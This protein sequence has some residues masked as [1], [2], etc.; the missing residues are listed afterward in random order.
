MSIAILALLIENV[1][2]FDRAIEC[3]NGQLTIAQEMGDKVTEASA[4]SNL[5]IVY[6]SLGKLKEAIEKYNKQMSTAKD[7]GD[8]SGEG[9]ACCN[10]GNAYHCLGNFTEALEYYK[11]F[12]NLAVERKD[13]RREGIA[14]GNLAIANHT[15][16]NFQ[17][18]LECST[19][20]LRIAQELN[21]RREEGMAYN[22]LGH[23]NAS[24]GNFQEA[25]DN[26]NKHLNIATEFGDSVGE[27]VAYSNL[28]CTYGE[29]GNFH[30]SLNY[31]K[32]HLSFAE[33]IKDRAAVG[34]AYGNIGNSYQK[35]G[36]YE[37]AID[38]H[39]ES[40]TIAK[41]VGDRDSEGR[42]YGNLGN[43]YHEI[44]MFQLALEHY[45]K[46]LNVAKEV[47]DKAGEGIAYGNLGNIYL[48]WGDFQ[49]AIEY[50]KKDLNI[51]KEVGSR[52]Q[53]GNVCYRLG[54][55]FDSK[56]S[57]HEALD[58]YKSSV[59]QLNFTRALL[60]SKDALKISFRELHRKAYN[61]LWRTLLR[62]QKTEEALKAAEQGRAQ[63]LSDGL[64]IH[65]GF[66]LP[67]PATR[68][69]LGHEETTSHISH[70]LP[71]QTVFL[72]LQG[73]TINFWVLSA[74]NDLEFR[75]K[76]IECGNAH[77]DAVSI[78]LETA[79][80]NVG[81]NVGVRCEN[82]SLED[83]SD[84]SPSERGGDAE[85][86]P[87]SSHCTI[88]F[89]QPLY[90]AVIK[91]IE[92]LVQGD[93]LIIVPDGPLCLAPLPA[94]SKTIRIRTV[95]SLTTLKLIL[96][97]PE[98][99]HRKTGAL[100]VGDPCLQKI[101]RWGKPKYRQLPKAKEEVEM[102]ANILKIP[103]LTGTDA[104]KREVLERISSVAL[105]HIA[106]HGRKETGEIALSPN[107]GWT[108]KIPR[109][110]DYMLKISDVQAVQLR[111]KLVVLSCCHSG[112]GEVKSEG[113][114]GIARAFLCAG[115]RSV[116]VTLWAVDDEATMEFMKSF[117]QHLAERKSVSVALHQA[118]KYLRESDRFCAAKYWAPFMLVGDD[119]TFEFGETS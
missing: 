113:V 65:Y 8:T 36:K 33:E 42:A 11:T 109:E 25:L 114:V 26:Y 64:R 69:L 60:P 17:Q 58:H 31:H 51:A 40:L 16:G 80:E 61:A 101:T 118:M 21:D 89:L 86:L 48:E 94:M 22:N 95:P 35:L 84:E 90:D 55:D 111:A 115:A 71:A 34:R 24:I 7:V 81:I 30:Q 110:E 67:L 32:K 108:S 37:E 66:K 75:R 53:E 54:C 77:D 23:A 39:D 3:H 78:L 97:S 47:K 76:K 92:D 12:L 52:L 49:K 28:A 9:S 13:R 46:H 102:I 29:L 10:L 41:E 119:V 14:Y 87:E 4:Y 82:R 88:E 104:T 19:K 63:A 93:D 59:E 62:L 107:P 43:A 5:G 70:D 15:L 112:R 6:E 18:T 100:L 96:E 106:T 117:Y 45:Q 1:G 50:H 2:N 27:G 91:P 105:V 44:G 79:L 72:A 116:L 56:G 83:L 73:N 99:Y 38:N 85:E 20:E 98:D 68:P 57:L 74:R 103:P